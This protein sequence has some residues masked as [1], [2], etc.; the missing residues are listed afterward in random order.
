VENRLLLFWPGIM[1][2]LCLKIWTVSNP[3]KTLLKF[4]NVSA[5]FPEVTVRA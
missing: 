3:F 4:I 1:S 2:R 5:S